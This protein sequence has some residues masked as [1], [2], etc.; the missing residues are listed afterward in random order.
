MNNDFLHGS[1]TAGDTPNANGGVG[2]VEP[3]QSAPRSRLTAVRD[4]T[5]AVAGGILGLVPHVLHH[6]GL[7]AGAALVTGAAGNALFFIVGMV[8]SIPLLRRLHRRFGSWWPPA[9][10]IAIFAGLFIL[11]ATVIGP[12]ITGEPGSDT[13]PAP[14]QTL[15]PGHNGHH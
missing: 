5:G 1:V 3:E 8:F 6:I 12:A 2:S 4:T 13:P 11:S 9:I 14:T 15:E 7:V 10:A